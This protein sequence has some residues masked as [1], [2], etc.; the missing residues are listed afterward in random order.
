MPNDHKKFHSKALQNVPNWDFGFENKPSGNLGSM[1]GPALTIAT[2][3][4]YIT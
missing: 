4:V 1:N 3:Y 2:K